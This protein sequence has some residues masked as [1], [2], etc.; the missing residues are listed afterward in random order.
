MQAQLIKEAEAAQNLHLRDLLQDEER[1]ATLSTQTDFAG[2]SILFDYSR[3][4]LQPSTV[5]ALCSLADELAIPAKL[6]SMMNGDVINTTENRSVLHT[7]C[8]Y[9]LSPRWQ[10]C[11]RC[12][13]RNGLT[14]LRSSLHT[15]VLSGPSVAAWSRRCP[16]L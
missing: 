6:N 10:V 15:V 5:D 3:Q 1:C 2:N 13:S 14:N 7:A 8:R 16:R 11:V 12:P 9:G 4:L